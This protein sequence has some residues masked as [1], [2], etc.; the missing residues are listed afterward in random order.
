[1]LEAGSRKGHEGMRVHAMRCMHAWV[2]GRS[3]LWCLARILA[4]FESLVLTQ[5]ATGFIH[6]VLG[7]LAT[8]PARVLASLTLSRTSR[9]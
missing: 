3:T 9:T 1:M 8:G 2:D 6:L 4:C 7:Q 5:L